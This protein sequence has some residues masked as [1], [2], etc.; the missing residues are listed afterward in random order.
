MGCVEAGAVHNTYESS[1]WVVDGE[2][3][4]GEVWPCLE[5]RQSEWS[6]G[7]KTPARLTPLFPLYPVFGIS[8][9]HRFSLYPVFAIYPVSAV[10][11]AHRP[12]E[13]WRGGH[14]EIPLVSIGADNVC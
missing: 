3:H 9:D 10:S 13:A 1:R 2:R 14:G 11:R 12:L 6:G 4:F 7:T 5:C 8:R